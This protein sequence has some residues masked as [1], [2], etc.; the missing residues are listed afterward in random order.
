MINR[1]ATLVSRLAMLFAVLFALAACGG[2]GGGSTF[3]ND[4]GT[5]SSGSSGSSGGSSSG[6]T[7][8]TLAL[9]LFDPL[10][11][12]TDTVTSSAPGTLTVSIPGGAANVLVSAETDIG[13]LL[14]ES[15]KALTNRQGVATFQIVAGVETGIGTVKATATTSNGDASGTLTIQ[16]KASTLSLALLDPLGNETN[17]VTSSSPGTLRVAVEGSGANVLVAASTDIGVLFPASG[18]A[19]TNSEGVATFQIE[20]G[21]EKGAGTATVTATTSAGVISGSLAFQVGDS[22]LRLGSF[23][24]SGTF[25]EN[26]VLIEPASTLSAGGNAQLSVVILNAEGDRVVTA[27]DVRFSSGCIAAGLATINP[28]VAQSVNGQASTLYS[29]E[30][31]SGTDNITASLVG[32]NAQAFGTMTIAGPTTNSV[33]FISAEPLLIVLRG[34]GGQGRDETSSVVFEVA[35]GAG[36]P[37]SGVNVGFSLTTTIGGLSLS[38]TSALSDGDGRVTVTVQAGDIPTVVRVLA[39]VDIGGGNVVTTV[40]DLM[41]VTTGLPDQDSISLAVGDCGDGDSFVVDGAMKIFLLCRELTVAMADKFNNPVVDGTAAVFT[42]EYGSIVGSCTTA[43]GTC[44]VEWRSQEPRFPTLTTG[45]AYVVGPASS[46][47]CPSF[48]GP[49]PIPCPEDLGS[50][51]GGRSAILV[52]A[53]GEESFIDRNGNGVMDQA[54]QNLFQN[55]P[56][57]FLDNNED[58]VYTPAL[59]QCAGGAMTLECISGEEETFSDFNAN[60]MYDLNDT[61]ALYN[62]LLCPVA[63]DGVWCSRKLINVRASHVVTL[64]DAPDWYFRFDSIF[65][66][67]TSETVTMYIADTYNNPPPAGATVTVTAKDNCKVVGKTAFDIF[68]YPTSGAYFFTFSTSSE[69]KVPPEAGSVEI[70]LSTPT[71]NETWIYPCVSQ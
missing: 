9:A 7:T 70:A 20:A 19:L 48:P 63:G 23:N 59:P 44:S 32:A 35:D 56:E 43:N 10:G 57:A 4:D 42:T 58:G 6:G 25:I 36:N 22:G 50:I 34:T 41:T 60:N 65:Q 18:T 39:T 69:I 71:S 38:K 66:V 64:G 68:N 5:S 51:R 12:A 49:G 2:G 11:V 26:Q 15:G 40:S 33:N 31:C 67:G 55:M 30:G 3:F 61:P 21:A 52:T 46:V 53:I 8:P 45:Q 62:G 28:T 47:S 13:T 17:S 24:N 37:L 16:V 29:A 54:E 27:E 14:P 1:G